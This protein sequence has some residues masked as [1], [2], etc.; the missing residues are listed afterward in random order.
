M[1][2]GSM[3]IVPWYTKYQLVWFAK[4]E[5]VTIMPCTMRGPKAG[6]AF[7]FGEGTN[8]CPPVTEQ[9]GFGGWF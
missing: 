2:Q 3:A 7:K 5:G 4:R 8:K 6:H 9:T 1:G